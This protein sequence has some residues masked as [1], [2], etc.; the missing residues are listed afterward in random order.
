MSIL[1]HRP[2]RMRKHE[3]NRSLIRENSLSVTDLIYP[4]FIIEGENKKEKIDSMPGIERLSIDQLL[5]E[6]QEIVDLK[7][8]AIALFPV[9]SNKKKTLEAE[10]SYNPDGLIQRA[11]RALKRSFPELAVITDVAL[12][13]FTSHG[14]DGVI[15]SQGY[16]LNDETVSVLIK[17]ALSHAQAGADIVAPSDM[18]DGRIGA[19]RFALEEKGYI[20]TNILAYSAKYASSF[21]GPFRDAVGSSASLGKSD[22]KTF[23][24]DPGNSDEAIRE[25]ELDI[26]EGADMVMIKPGL[27]YLDIVSRVKQT[28]GVPTFAYHVSGE[29][30]MLKAASQ[31]NWIDERS[32][33]LETLLCFKR[34]GAD[35]VLTYYA[36]DAAKWLYE[37]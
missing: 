5:I 24:M 26:S 25:V 27:P 16:V 30:A 4:L 1:T 29:Y 20:Y 31:N 37:G 22:K 12:D 8:Q 15:D 10:E 28:F 3:F 18:M 9:I 14:L 35:A 36:K 11:V 33:V 7:I 32:T 6:A 2:R 13:P 23:Q 34:A 17:Q 21:Y 19:I